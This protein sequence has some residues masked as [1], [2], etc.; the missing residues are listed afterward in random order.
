MKSKMN[1]MVFMVVIMLSTLCTFA[2]VHAADFKLNPL[3]MEG[4]TIYL[5][6]QGAFGVGI[7]SNIATFKDTVELRGMVVSSVDKV[8][9]NMAGIGIGI[10]LP[11]VITKLGGTWL[12]DNINTSIG[13]TGLANLNG[14]AQIQ[15]AIY[16]TVVSMSY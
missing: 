6:S 4:D 7:G 1:K 12:L 2:T 3:N 5:P 14:K 16:L 13:I 11:K 15:P 9:V 10:N 8:D